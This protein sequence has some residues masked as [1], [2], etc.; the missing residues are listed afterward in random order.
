M[1]MQICQLV[2]EHQ[3]PR[4]HHNHNV[5]MKWM[6]DN[7]IYMLRDNSNVKVRFLT[8]IY[9]GLYVHFREYCYLE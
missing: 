2:K 7:F 5:W 9:Y 4:A 8:R 6:C 3:C 1:S